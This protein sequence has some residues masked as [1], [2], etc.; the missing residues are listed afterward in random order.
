MIIDD[1]HYMTHAEIRRSC[2]DEP[3]YERL[4]SSPYLDGITC[5]YVDG[6]CYIPVRDVDLAWKWMYGITIPPE[7]WD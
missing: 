7:A 1:E 2:I 6:V 5:A 4:M 3:I